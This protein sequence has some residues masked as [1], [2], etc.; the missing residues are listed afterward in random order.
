MRA[1]GRES[2]L[3]AAFDTDSASMTRMVQRL[4]R[5]GFVRRRP[6]PS[7]GRVT[8]VETTPAGVALRPQVEKL[9]ADLEDVAT[10]DRT[11]DERR[12]TSMASNGWR[13]TWRP[14]PI[15]RVPTSQPAGRWGAGPGSAWQCGGGPRAVTLV[16]APDATWRH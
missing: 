4:E 10:G 2:Y 8:L 3:A 5:A 11:Q 15:Q 1:R 6:D 12:V 7:N 14:G 13:T 16:S 9:W